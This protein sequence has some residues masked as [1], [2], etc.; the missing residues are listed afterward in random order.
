MSSVDSVW[1]TPDRRDARGHC[2]T[3]AVLHWHL[4]RVKGLDAGVFGA[5]F[6]DLMSVFL[7]R[8][9]RMRLVIVCFQ[10]SD[11]GYSAQDSQVQ[12]AVGF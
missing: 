7:L 11:A 6:R 9:H 5:L 8:P 12:L 4:R 1:L 10:D 2:E 3:G